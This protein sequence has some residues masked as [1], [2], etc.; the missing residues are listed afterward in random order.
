MIVSYTCVITAV[1][2]LWLITTMIDPTDPTQ[3]LHREAIEMKVNFNTHLYK[4]FCHVCQTCVSKSSFHC[5]KCNRCVDMFDH[6]CKW[7]NNCIGAKN[8]IEFLALVATTEIMVLYHIVFNCFDVVAQSRLYPNFRW[9]FY[10]EVVFVAVDFIILG[11]NSALL[12]IH[13][14]LVVKKKTTLQLI[15]ERRKINKIYPSQK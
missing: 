12:A 14:Y 8:Y 13:L 5:K 11:F 6:H 3:I 15:L 1:F 7:V 10:T 2:V 9:L 4:Y